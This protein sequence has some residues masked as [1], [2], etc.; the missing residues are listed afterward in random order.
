MFRKAPDVVRIL[1]LQVLH[2][3]GHGGLELR[4]GCWRSLQVDLHGVPF[5]EQRFDEGVAG[6][7]HGLGQ[8]SVQEVI[9]LVH[10]SF[11]LVQHLWTAHGAQRR[12][13]AQGSRKPE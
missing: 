11:H 5:G 12:L 10:E 6:L 7:P 13:T 2:Q 9:V 1:G 4:P 3:S 8:V